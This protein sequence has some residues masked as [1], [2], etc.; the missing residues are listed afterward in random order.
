MD[1]ERQGAPARDLWDDGIEDWDELFAK[2]SGAFD[3]F[4]FC[5][6]IDVD[7]EQLREG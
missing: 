5:A 4:V 3:M 6:G 7:V 1:L 2:K